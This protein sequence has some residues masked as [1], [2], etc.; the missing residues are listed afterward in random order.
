MTTVEVTWPPTL[1]ELKIDMKLDPNV[2]NEARDAQL[3][4]D[5][6]AT[7]AFVQRVRPVYRYDPLDPAQLALPGVTADH[8]LGTLRLAARWDTR[9]R[10]PDGMISMAELG[11]ARVTSYDVDIDRM[12]QIGR[13]APMI[14]A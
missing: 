4:M 2:V 1:D 14:F 6:D 12:L 10:S 11:A 3:T 8:K 13:F 9:R 7:V 5:L